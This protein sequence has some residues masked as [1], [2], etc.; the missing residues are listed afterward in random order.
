VAMLGSRVIVSG[1]NGTMLY[2]DSLDDF[3]L[4]N[5]GTSDWLESVAISTNLA[6]A[7]GDNAAIYTSSTGVAWARQ[8]VPFTAWLRSVAHEG[9]IFVTVG[10]GGFTAASMNGTNWM[11]R[12]SGTS[13]HLNRVFW[14]NDRFIALGNSGVALQSL[15]RGS[16]WQPFI[17]STGATGSL[18]SGAASPDAELVLGDHE[19]RLRTNA[20]AGWT[21]EFTASAPHRPPQWIY[22]SG[23]WA[24]SLFLAAGRTGM[25][26]EGFRTNATSYSWFEN[27][28]SVRN[29]FWDLRRF[30]DLY[31]AVGD[32]G[33]IMTSINGIRWDLE[34]LRPASGST[35]NLENL[36]FLG[37]GGNAKGLVAVGNQ[38]SVFY[39]PNVETNVAGLIWHEIVPRPT[40]NDL[41]GVVGIGN[42]L[43][44]TGGRGTI[45]SSTN[46]TNWI[47]RSSGTTNF[48]SSVEAFPGGLVATGDRGVILTSPDSLLWTARSSGTTNWL[49]RV[50]YLNGSLIAVGQGGTILTSPDGTNWTARSSGTTHWLNAIDCVDGRY[51]AVGVQGT[52][53][54]STNAIQWSNIG[55]ITTKSLYGA[56][57]HAGQFV[58]AGIEGAI[59]RAQVT[60]RTTPVEIQFYTRNNFTNWSENVFLFSGKPDQQFSLQHSSGLTNWQSS[61]FFELLSGSSTL[62]YLEPGF[63]LPYE[64]Y[65]T[66]LEP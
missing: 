9:G 59:L 37:V 39:S 4:V 11:V 21:N 62:L 48:L 57:S 23:I 20:L 2:A 22:Y 51:L 5:L 12:G 52:V 43:I 55:T 44:A 63:N 66:R 6:V 13:A 58:T 47:A 1:A 45:L 33:T 53:L 42:F 50:R 27:S 60:P 17:P 32:H 29:W 19:F 25:L 14:M 30:P 49:Y 24:N 40:T 7:V 3:R 64:F 46:G 38:G 16:T 26:V 18:F 34:L 10:E 61:A 15:D 28:P 35:V 54:T 41:Q 65:R 8:P 56:A 31:V 36:I